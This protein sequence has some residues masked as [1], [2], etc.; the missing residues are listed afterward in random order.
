MAAEL[1]ATKAT[2]EAQGLALREMKAQA[3][4]QNNAGGAGGAGALRRKTPLQVLPVVEL[5]ALKLKECSDV[6]RRADNP[7]DRPIGSADACDVFDLEF[8]RLGRA[9]EK[10]GNSAMKHEARVLAPAVSYLHDDFWA[11]GQLAAQVPAGELRES[12]RALYTRFSRTYHFLLFRFDFL[13]AMGEMG[14]TQPGLVSYIEQ[15]RSPLRGLPITSPD[16]LA[17]V[18]DYNDKSL[19]ARLKNAANHSFDDSDNEPRGG[20]YKGRKG[21]QGGSAVPGGPSGSGGSRAATRSQTAAAQGGA[22]G[23]A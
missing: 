23:S 16:V 11:F 6:P 15:L 12:F 22:V 8:N 1:A 21:K 19:G 14:R 20:G 18:R 2:L 13:L 10:G 9:M 7:S 4:G 17:A 5:P 3:D